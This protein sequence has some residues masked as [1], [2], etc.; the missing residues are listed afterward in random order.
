MEY[1]DLFNFKMENFS[2]DPP[3]QMKNFFISQLTEKE[4]KKLDDFFSGDEID[5]LKDRFD[6]C[7]SFMPFSELDGMNVDYLKITNFLKDYSS[8]IS[9]YEKINF[10][11]EELFNFM[12]KNDLFI[13]F[14]AENGDSEVSVDFTKNSRILL[15][16]MSFVEKSII[17]KDNKI[18][19]EKTK[20]ISDKTNKLEVKLF[21]RSMLGN[22]YIEK[23]D[24]APIHIKE[25]LYDWLLYKMSWSIENCGLKNFMDANG[26]ELMNLFEFLV[27]DEN[28]IDL[29]T[30][31]VSKEEKSKILE[32]FMFVFDYVSANIVSGNTMSEQSCDVAN[33]NIKCLGKWLEKKS[34][35]IT[36]EN[37]SL[38]RKK[39]SM[40]VYLLLGSNKK[41]NSKISTLIDNKNS[42]FFNILG[43]LDKS[44]APNFINKEKLKDLF[45]NF[46]LTSEGEYNFFKYFCDKIYNYPMSY[47]KSRQ[48]YKSEVISG[49]INE[50]ILSEKFLL[51][52]E[53][54][55]KKE[56]KE[57]GF[58]DSFGDILVFFIKQKIPLP[59]FFDDFKKEIAFFIRENTKGEKLQS[60]FAAFGNTGV[61]KEDLINSLST[62]NAMVEKSKILLEIEDK[63]EKTDNEDKKVKKS[64]RF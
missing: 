33:K 54:E 24:S 27:L 3:K 9:Q 52:L 20:Y 58:I 34:D 51:N 18:E 48:D 35:I 36:S 40:S 12:L 44:Y 6:F 64:L 15:K 13:S 61:L 46:N 59:I 23:I 39:D 17:E 42:F 8:C 1:I 4:K 62:L 14:L 47:D 5:F 41:I 26:F 21:D 2:I 38:I 31:M 10:N 7:S 63:K 11:K 53:K 28:K 49:F 19:R 57:N 56:K 50:I 22:N 37:V 45:K 55:M 32:G 16:M 30:K 43:F 29:M 25:G 60:K